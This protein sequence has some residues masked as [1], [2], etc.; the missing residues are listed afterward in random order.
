MTFP[1][2]V[3]MNYRD[4][5]QEAERI[6]SEYRKTQV[7]FVVNSGTGNLLVTGR[8]NSGIEDFLT[9]LT[10][11]LNQHQ[12]DFVMLSVTDEMSAKIA[13]E[14]IENLPK[15]ALV[16]DPKQFLFANGRIPTT[17][18]MIYFTQ[19]WNRKLNMEGYGIFAH[20]IAFAAL[21]NQDLMDYPVPFS[22]IGSDMQA[23]EYVSVDT[24][25]FSA[26]K[27]TNLV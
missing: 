11:H 15:T 18:N 25:S 27:R 5:V 23:G 6:I 4:S 26:I 24:G 2:F 7:D 12:V 13:F 8:A 1:N 3:S 16:F 17:T 9:T 22:A 10:G 21:R 20:H 14:S 19:H